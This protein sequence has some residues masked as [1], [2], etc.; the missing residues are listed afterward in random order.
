MF[1]SRMW[2]IGWNPSAALPKETKHAISRVRTTSRALSEKVCEAGL[3]SIPGRTARLKTIYLL[4]IAAEIEHALMVQYL[5]AAY[6]I[7]EMFA[8]G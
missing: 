6:A 8:E 1:K 7:D 2:G 5:Y 3:L 4:Q